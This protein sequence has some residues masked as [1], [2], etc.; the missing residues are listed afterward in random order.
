[1]EQY[2]T[3]SNSSTEQ[4]VVQAGQ[5]QQQ[6]WENYLR[7]AGGPDIWLQ[8]MSC[9]LQFNWAFKVLGE[10]DWMHSWLT[11]LSLDQQFYFVIG[12]CLNISISNLYSL[13]KI[14]ETT[15]TTL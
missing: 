15:D 1:M 5:I 10:I 4:I 13:Y 8:C 6:V 12:V 14:V 2:T 7:E 9:S 3:N 11:V